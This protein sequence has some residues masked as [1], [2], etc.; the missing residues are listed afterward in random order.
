MQ[1]GAL[2]EPFTV[3]PNEID[4]SDATKYF[5]KIK[6]EIEVL[7]ILLLIYYDMFINLLDTCVVGRSS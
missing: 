3:S 5:Q 6:A 7:N 4:Y 2:S 1:D